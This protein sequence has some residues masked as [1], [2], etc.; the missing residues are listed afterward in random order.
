M[1]ADMHLHTVYSDGDVTPEKV[2]NLG[3]FGGVGLLSVTDHDTIKGV[4]EARKAARAGKIK[5]VSG[6]EISAYF[7][8]IKFHTLCYGADEGKL[9]G[10]LKGLFEQSFKRA[11]DI[12]FKLKKMGCKLNLEEVAAE[13]YSA[14][15]PVHGIHFA[16]VMLKKGYTKSIGEY[17][18]IYSEAGNGAY[19]RIGRPAPEE[20]LDAINYAGGLAVLAH[21]GRINMDGRA[22]TEKIS[23]LASCGLGGIECYYTTHTKIQTAYFLELAK[24][25][26]LYITGGSDTHIADGVREIGK[27]RFTPDNELLQRLRID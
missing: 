14:D 22:L 5:F 6:V 11:E 8:D 3:I 15:V 24:R 26:G 25:L 18:K 16:R 17:F 9:D 13:R 23:K 21:P 12:I 19:S 10:F 27:P 7:G 1:I 4:N 20:A 2:V